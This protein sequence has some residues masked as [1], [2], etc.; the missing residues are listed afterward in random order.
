MTE[1]AP[2][3]VLGAPRTGTTLVRRLLSAHSRVAIPPESGFLVEYLEAEDVPLAERKR[4][5]C[6]EPELAY[7]GTRPMAAELRDLPSIEACFRFLHDKY[8][9]EQ[10]K[11]LWG[12]KTPKMVRRAELLAERFP[13]ARFVH[14]VRDGRAVASSLER[15]DAH[16]LHPLYGARRYARD[17]RLGLELEARHP[18]RVLRLRYEDLVA[19]PE[20][21]L[22]RLCDFLGLELEP[23]MLSAEG[24]QVRLTPKELDRGHHLNVD[25]PIDATF[26]EKWRTQLDPASVRMVEHVAGEVIR[27]LGYDVPDSGRPTRR[28]LADARLRHLRAS[29]R[30]AVEEVTQRPDVWRIARRR[31]KLGSLQ[32]MV[33]DHFA[34]M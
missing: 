16:R 12:Q 25:K 3:F 5:L 32:R 11:D 24:S 22:R 9:G 27:E 14:V 19:D 30:K 13:D 20:P 1:P 18:D 26:T 15:S 28:Q 23:A 6:E 29:A 10:G 4:L 7:W 34:G 33:R 8:A 31:W 17:T 2:F 21:A